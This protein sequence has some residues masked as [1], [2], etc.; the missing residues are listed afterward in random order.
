MPN[1][2]NTALVEIFKEEYK[3][4]SSVLLFNY[5]GM[6]VKREG[7]LREKLA[8]VGGKMGVI[9]N[10]VAKIAIAGTALESA[11]EYL[12]GPVAII[13]GGEDIVGIAKATQNYLDEGGEGA[14]CF[15]GAIIEGIALDADKASEVHKMPSKK[16]IQA[17][18]V[19]LALGPGSKLV[20]SI[21]AP[22]ANIGGIVK[23]L[24]EKKEHEGAA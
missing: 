15:A 13:S 20:S 4:V 12:N 2:V 21:I 23:A 10:S 22:A 8:Q 6:G 7:L 5:Q 24:V 9:K 3:D 19:G 11:S 16:D 17:L 1:L 18:I 14:G